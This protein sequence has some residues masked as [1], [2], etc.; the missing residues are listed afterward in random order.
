MS[1]YVKI[2]LPEGVLES[3]STLAEL[4]TKL[5]EILIK[6]GLLTASAEN[7]PNARSASTSL[8]QNNEDST[9][10]YV[11]N[12]CL[13][14]IAQHSNVFCLPSAMFLI[15]QITSTRKKFLKLHLSC[16]GAAWMKSKF[17][18]KDCRQQIGQQLPDAD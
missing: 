1:S 3:S 14:T 4:Q 11:L 7:T 5:E 10:G 6:H 2:T 15:M 18:S 12:H 16:L 9:S 8:D 17:E 13:D